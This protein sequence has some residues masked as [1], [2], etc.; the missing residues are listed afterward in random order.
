MVRG[1]FVQVEV[2][3]QVLAH[4]R[5]GTSVNVVG[6]RASG[7]TALL[8]HVVQQLEAEG[9]GTVRITGVGPLQDRPLAAL[10]VN[11]IHVPTSALGPAAFAGAVRALEGEVTSRPSVLLVDDAD[12]V[13]LATTGVIVA[14]RTR[15]PVPVLAVS[16]LPLDH[17]P[18]RR[19]L[20]E[21]LHPAVRLVMPPL[22]YGAV[23]RLVH[24]LLPGPVDRS[25]VARIATA[26]GGLPGL[27]SS[28]VEV[29]SRT[30]RLTRGLDGWTWHGELW[31]PAL[32]QSVEP[33]IAQLGADALAALTVV[34]LSGTI[35]LRRATSLM[36][37]DDL[38]V[39][40]AGGLVQVVRVAQE[41]FVAVFPP[42]LARFLT[43]ERSLVRTVQAQ[44]RIVTVGRSRRPGAADAAGPERSV[45]ASEGVLAPL[46]DRRFAE[47]WQAELED[48]RREWIADPVPSTALALV[49]ALHA[50]GAPVAEV[51]R[52]VQDTV[53][54][55]DDP[56]GAALLRTTHAIDV[57]LR[58]RDPQSALAEL[59]RTDP[60]PG[61]AG[62]DRAVRAHVQLVT[63]RLPA[64]EPLH[65]APGDAPEAEQALRAVRISL[66]LAAGRIGAAE[67][68]L[69]GFST[70]L[71]TLSLSL[72]LSRA[73]GL[74]LDGRVPEGIARALADLAAAHERLDAG[75]VRTHAYVAAFGLLTAGRLAEAEGLL[76]QVLALS[77][78]E[79]L[80]VH[81]HDAGLVLAA[82]TAHFRGD[83]QQATALA[84]QAGA[85]GAPRGPYAWMWPDTI[86]VLVGGERAGE[87]WALAEERW[88]AG[89][90][91]AGAVAAVE[92]MERD[93]DPE[94]A[95]R[96]LPSGPHECVLVAALSHLVLALGDRDPD[97][98]AAAGALLEAQGLHLYATRAAVARAVALRAAGDLP[99]AAEQAQQAWV[100]ATGR[101]GAA[102]GLFAPLAR[103]VEL[104]AREREVIRRTGDGLPSSAVAAALGLSVRTVDNHIQNGLRKVGVRTRRELVAAVDTWA[105]PVESPGVSGAFA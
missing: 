36:S 95:R 85:L 102:R 75:A 44:H 63:G 18:A 101:G 76:S 90:V 46:L 79:G 6:M 32:A 58:R 66:D 34:A 72:A 54:P 14:V 86:E 64:P 25:T 92:A 81:C 7:R 3:A 1:A 39:L 91:V 28:L 2:A 59:D 50:V 17:Q 70:D 47:H 68:E 31:D 15:V 4:L 20:A 97:A 5:S 74:I 29:G 35:E 99:A 12:D 60:P 30:G 103:D 23:L 53:L 104:S 43:Q 98:L 40:E 93:P 82:A 26:S 83:Q 37:W 21:E 100:A 13:D 45:P 55:A 78:H 69:A 57:G 73:Y 42:L 61:Y 94:R 11:G 84:T 33:L 62:V 48:C 80:S 22:D 38:A 19:P 105:A 41:P 27:V 8:G 67:G 96:L 65:P 88:A 49:T 89:F 56:Q 10:A 51:D 9:F 71:S 16:R 52:V 24:D 77:S 87:L